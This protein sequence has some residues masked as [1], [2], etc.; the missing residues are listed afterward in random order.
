MLDD[1]IEQNVFKL[2]D[3]PEVQFRWFF[4]AYTL[5]ISGSSVDIGGFQKPAT[6]EKNLF[7]FMKRIQIII[8]T[9]II[10]WFFSVCAAPNVY[11]NGVS[12]AFFFM[13]C[14]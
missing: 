10:H 12:L 13:N 8:V 11:K 2:A 3:L 4:A 7:I 14:D 6:V 5:D 9:V 1:L